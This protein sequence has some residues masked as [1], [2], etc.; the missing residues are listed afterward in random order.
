[1]ADSEETR[2]I[3]KIKFL[4]LAVLPRAKEETTERFHR[5][6]SLQI[7]QLTV[8]F[9]TVRR[10]LTWSFFELHPLPERS[11]RHQNP[12][13]QLE[14]S[15]IRAVPGRRLTLV[16]ERK[17]EQ[18][19]DDQLTCIYTISL[20]GTRPFNRMMRGPDLTDGLLEVIMGL[21]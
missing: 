4:A 2:F 17:W 16:N 9:P 20:S 14:F 8:Y 15:T 21:F 5:H 18:Q 10:A 1:M 6:A 3:G 7:L 19:H 13:V 11:S 12:L